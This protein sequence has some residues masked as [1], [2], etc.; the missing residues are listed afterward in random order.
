MTGVHLL[1]EEILDQ[2]HRSRFAI[3][4]G[5]TKMYRDLKHQ[6][7]WRDLKRDVAEYVAHCYTCQ[8]V[9]AEHQRPASLLQPLP[10][11]EWKWDHITMDFVSSLPWTNNSHNVVW[12]VVD[13]LTKLAHFLGM[14]TTNSLSTL[15]QF[16]V[17]EIVRLHGV[18]LFVVS[19]RDPQFVSNFWQGL[20]EAMGIWGHNSVLVQRF[21]LRLT[22]SL[23]G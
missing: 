15:S 13:Q 9:K 7:W 10:V 16:Y 6:F 23:R 5:C 3:H 4:P 22:G 19:D 8:Q 11:S 12:V 17:T 2:A 1:R 14:K 18:P 21:I 20:Y